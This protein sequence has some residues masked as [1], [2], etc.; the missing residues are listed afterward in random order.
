[1]DRLLQFKRIHEAMGHPLATAPQP[2][3]G[4][5]MSKLTS[6]DLVEDLAGKRVTCA[7]VDHYGTAYPL[8]TICLDDGSIVQVNVSRWVQSGGI[9]AHPDGLD[10]GTTYKDM[11]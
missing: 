9:P 4:E 2:S 8:L 7:R 5:K 1:M 6:R 11:P 10:S 3:R